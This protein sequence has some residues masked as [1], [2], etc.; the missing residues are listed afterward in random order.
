VAQDRPSHGKTLDGYVAGPKWVTRLPARSGRWRREAP[1]V[2]APT[3]WA[4]P[5]TWK[6]QPTGRPRLNRGRSD[7]R[8]PQGGGSR[9]AWNGRT[10]KHTR[11]ARG[12]LA[13]EASRLKK[14]SGGDIVAHGAHPRPVPRA[15]RARRRNT[16]SWSIQC[17]VGE[18]GRCSKTSP[19]PSHAAR[20]RRRR[21]RT[22][23]LGMVYSRLDP[24]RPGHSIGWCAMAGGSRPAR[25]QLRSWR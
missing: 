3:S 5:P 21:S 13:A 14:E 25:S 17:A 7:E 9:R 15:E 19:E 4:G 23:A 24:A 16:G 12:E 18:P 22:G 8:H 6:W 1:R 10:G 20:R 11:I 2:P